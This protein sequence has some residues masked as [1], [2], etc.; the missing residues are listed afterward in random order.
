ML[1]TEKYYL[2]L[3][4]THHHRPLN[5]ASLLQFKS[6]LP[7]LIFLLSTPV[8]LKPHLFSFS[9]L[10][11][12]FFVAL[13]LLQLHSPSEAAQCACATTT[14][15][16]RSAAGTS[17]NVVHVM[18]SG[19]CATYSGQSSQ[20]DGYTWLHVTVGGQVNPGIHPALQVF[21]GRTHHS[22]HLVLVHVLHGLTL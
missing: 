22:L 7:S 18:N 1:R 10:Q 8:S 6:I 4:C 11:M 9:H 13:L 3:R 5:T 19:D 2:A 14:L 20:A 21:W 17:H 12:R 15:N 16:V